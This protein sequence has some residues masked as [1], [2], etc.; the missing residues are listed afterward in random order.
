[1]AS[2]MNLAHNIKKLRE[3]RHVTQEQMLENY[4]NFLAACLS[5]GLYRD[6]YVSFQEALTA[7]S[8]DAAKSLESELS[9][10]FTLGGDLCKKLEKYE[11]AFAHWNKALSISAQYI[12]AMYSIALCYRELSHYKEEAETW[13][14]IIDWLEEKGA[15]DEIRWPREMLASATEKQW[16]A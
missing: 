7:V 12:D 14:K 2:D 6:G 15:L 5:A 16:S 4:N 8:A 11:E 9:I 10:L 3:E 1:M 13:Q